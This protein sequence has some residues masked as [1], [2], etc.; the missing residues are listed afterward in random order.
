MVSSSREA[1]RKLLSRSATTLCTRQGQGHKI[2]LGVQ[3]VGYTLKRDAKRQEPC[4][5]IVLLH[6]GT[7]DVSSRH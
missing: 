2:G 7:Q 5:H 4:A 3:G 6:G 1:H